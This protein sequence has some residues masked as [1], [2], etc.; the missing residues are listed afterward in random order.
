ACLAKDPADRPTPA[1]LLDLFVP[2]SAPYTPTVAV[3]TEPAG[4]V[5]GR[6]VPDRS[7]SDRS[8]SD[9][10]H[11]APPRKRVLP[12]V[13]VAAAV[14]AVLAG[15]L[16]VAKPWEG[17]SNSRENVGSSGKDGV[18]VPKAFH[19][20]WEGKFP[21]QGTKFEKYAM[22]ELGAEESDGDAM[23]SVMGTKLLCVTPAGIKSAEHDADS[24]KQTVRLGTGEIETGMPLIDFGLCRDRPGGSVSYDPANT[25]QLVWTVGGQVIKLTRQE[26]ISTDQ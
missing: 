12:A 2:G 15:G 8:V 25:N 23:V 21:G 17:G 6:P 13:L 22:V 1:K 4:A 18:T 24:G 19:G 14:I 16:L 5:D 3:P 26:N 9:R 11:P 10:P 7:V 20:K